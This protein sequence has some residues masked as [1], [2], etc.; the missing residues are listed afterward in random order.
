VLAHLVDLFLGD[1]LVLLAQT[2]VHVEPT[3]YESTDST[4]PKPY[5]QHAHGLGVQATRRLSDVH[6]LFA[7]GFCRFGDHFC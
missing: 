2:V 5:H 4:Y 1:L 7:Y 6:G 3:G